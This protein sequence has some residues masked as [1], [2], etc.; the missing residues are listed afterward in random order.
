TASDLSRIK[1][2]IS[3]EDYQ[4]ALYVIE[5]NNRVIKFAEA[6]EKDDLT[7]L[8][9]LLFQSHDGLSNQ[10]KVSCTELDFLVTKAQGYSDVIGARM[11]GGGFGGC[12]INLVRKS[13]ME[14][15]KNEVSNQFKEEFGRECSV[16]EVKLSQGTH[17]VK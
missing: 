5:E 9:N 2:E 16:Y 3:K 13:G 14:R 17:L 7:T 15:F 10:Y 12:T 6:I 11:M 8:G 4:K 1:E